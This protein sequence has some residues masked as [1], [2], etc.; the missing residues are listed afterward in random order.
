MNFLI[1]LFNGGEFDRRIMEKT[2]CLNYTCS[3]W[4]SDKDVYE[5]QVCYKFDKRISSYKGEVTSI[6]QKS[7]LPDR[8]GWLVEEV[9]TLHGIPLGDYFTVRI[10]NIES[11]I[12]SPFFFF[13]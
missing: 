12:F 11:Q 10:C 2:G 9:L 5:R 4:E 1:E 8:T 3:P 7:P 6:Q 13:R